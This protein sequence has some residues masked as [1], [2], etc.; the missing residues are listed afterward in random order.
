MSRRSSDA[1]SRSPPSNA[2]GPDGSTSS[3]ALDRW[4]PTENKKADAL[5]V[6]LFVGWDH[7]RNYF[8]FFAA[9]FFVAFFAAFFLAAM[10]KSP[11]LL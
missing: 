10:R 2:R 7:Y 8:F 5:R 11:G 6:G 3:A 1:Q 4:T 9:F